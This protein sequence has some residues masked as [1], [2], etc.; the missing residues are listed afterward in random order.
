MDINV[1]KI[2]LINWI[3]GCENEDIVLFL[4]QFK[5]IENPAD[6]WWNS[7]SEKRKNS[8][9]KGADQASNGQTIS[10]DTVMSKLRSKFDL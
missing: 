8:I 2:E 1:R 6:N 4:E 9:E 3:A 10:N 7:L 5:H